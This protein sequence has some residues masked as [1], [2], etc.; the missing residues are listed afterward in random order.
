MA[1]YAINNLVPNGQLPL[2]AGVVTGAGNNSVTTSGAGVMPEEIFLLVV[3]ATATTN[4]T[5]KAGAYPPALS[6]GQGDLVL[7]TV[8]GSALLGPFTGARFLQS[9]GTMNIVSATPANTTVTAF[10]LPRTA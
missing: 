9:D 5:I 3:T 4:L 10:R 1:T 2:P 6:S 7:S 8:V